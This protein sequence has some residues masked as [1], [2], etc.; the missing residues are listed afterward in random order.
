MATVELSEFCNVADAAKIIGCTDGRVRQL[1]LAGELRGRKINDRAWLVE[2]ADAERVRD[3]EPGRGMP[4]TNPNARK[5]RRIR[6]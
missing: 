5:Q 4:R 3:I 2:I 6:R 1:L